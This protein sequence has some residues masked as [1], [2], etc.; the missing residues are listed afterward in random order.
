MTLGHFYFSNS[1]GIESYLRNHISR[2][3]RD[4]LFELERAELNSKIQTALSTLPPHAIICCHDA[5]IISAIL[6][7]RPSQKIALFLHGDYPYYIATAIEFGLAAQY[8]ICVTTSIQNKLPKYLT[9][10]SYVQ[11]PVVPRK[12]Y[13][14]PPKQTLLLF[15][16][17]AS[18][19]K[20]AHLLPLI[21]N[22]IKKIHPSVKWNLIIGHS[23]EQVPCE[24][25]QWLT[26]ERPRINLQS[27]ITN[28]EVQSIITKST[29]LILPSKREGHPM[30][31]A[32]TISHGRPCFTLEYSPDSWQHIPMCPYNIVK[33]SRTA[34]ELA[35]SVIRYLSLDKQSRTR[36]E[37]NNIT[38]SNTVYSQ[39]TKRNKFEQ[40]ADP[41]NKKGTII[42]TP[43]FRKIVNKVLALSC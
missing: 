5:P 21:D 28:D 32:E 43:L 42:R 10:R 12:L 27:Q 19:G 17:R 35:T 36:I 3:H 23:N 16:G 26:A 24:F 13:I 18:N 37:D 1:G 29:A 40:W 30:A 41:L 22:H 25:Q 2:S 39:E 14:R 8:I 31:V 9:R 33:P 15:I 34:D 4:I 7:Q 20:G 38:F 6:E 11:G